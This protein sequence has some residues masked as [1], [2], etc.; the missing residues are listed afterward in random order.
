MAHGVIVRAS[1]RRAA[2]TLGPARGASAVARAASEG[3]D[4]GAKAAA[5]AVPAA[6]LA[7]SAALLASR[8]LDAPLESY[9]TTVGV[10][11]ISALNP[12]AWVEHW[13]HAINMSVVLFAMGGYG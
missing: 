3:S 7:G 13:F 4:T 9:L 8:A 2:R 12:P 10:P 5:V 11:V 6:A 1:A